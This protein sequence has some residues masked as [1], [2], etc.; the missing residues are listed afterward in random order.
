MSETRGYTPSVRVVQGR[1]AETV[2]GSV[3]QAESVSGVEVAPYEGAGVP[4]EGFQG[5]VRIDKGIS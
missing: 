2:D 1:S 5:G 4:Y 3:R